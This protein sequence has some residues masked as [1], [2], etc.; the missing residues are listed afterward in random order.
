MVEEVKTL[1]PNLTVG[2][3]LPFNI[4]GPPV[5]KADFLTMEYSTI[6]R[7]FIESAEND[8]KQVFVWTPNSEDDISRMMFYGVDG[9]ITDSMATLN[10]VIEQRQDQ[11]TYSDKLLNFVIGIG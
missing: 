3:T 4:V 5:T 7:N 8:G 6:N 1:T 10:R 11:T 2:Y 9:I